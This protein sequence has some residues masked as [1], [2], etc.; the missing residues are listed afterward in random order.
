MSTEDNK[1]ASHCIGEAINAHDYAALKELMSPTMYEEFSQ[2]FREALAAFPDYMGKNIDMF[3]EGDKVAVRWT[4]VGTHQGSFMGIAPTGKQVTF[5]GMSIDQY[6]D[7]KLI[8]YWIEMDMLGVL[9]QLGV[10]PAP[11]KAS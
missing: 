6:A 8:E 3:A 2:G 10:G 9:Q 5:S 7:G 1:A 4:A 11:L